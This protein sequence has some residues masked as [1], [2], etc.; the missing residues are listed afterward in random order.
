MDPGEQ[1]TSEMSR[2]F[3]EIEGAR[4]PVLPGRFL[5]TLRNMFP[6]FGEVDEGGIYKQQDAEECWSQL[7]HTL[8]N[9]LVV[10]H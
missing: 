5:L 10:S 6:Q 1:L 3:R 8:G 9:K 4:N 7:T 2:L